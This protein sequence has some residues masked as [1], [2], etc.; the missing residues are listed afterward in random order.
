M[1]VLG[2]LL[3]FSA[4]PLFAEHLLSTLPW[5]LSPLE[6]QQ[7]AGLMMWIPAGVLLMSYALLT[8]GQEMSRLGRRT[9]LVVA[10]SAPIPLRAVSRP[11]QTRERAPRPV[12]RVV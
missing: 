7:L 10:Y 2:A 1:S 3:A 4:R 11:I 12:L 5:G 9:R 8:L 6:D